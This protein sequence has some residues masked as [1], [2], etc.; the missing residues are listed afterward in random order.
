MRL[1]DK[2][3]RPHSATAYV[4]I[5]GPDTSCSQ[6]FF[7]NRALV[8]TKVDACAASPHITNERSR[9][10]TYQEKVPGDF[11]YSHLPRQIP[12][13]QSSQIPEQKQD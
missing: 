3:L 9:R 1:S 6:R 2:R 7:G 8:E 10:G 4:K 12:V 13:Q 11:K 5:R